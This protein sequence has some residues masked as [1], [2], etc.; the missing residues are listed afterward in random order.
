MATGALLLS[1]TGF[2]QGFAESVEGEA[3]SAF[4]GN[5]CILELESGDE[6]RGTFTS[7]TYVNN[8]FSKITVKLDN[9]EKQKFTPD[10]LVSMKIRSSDL[11]KMMMISESGSSL[12]E[13]G[14]TNFNDILNR[15]YIIFETA[16]TPKKT[17]TKR[18][19]QLLNAGFDNRIKVFAEPSAKTG[20]LNVGGIQVTGGEDAAYL[21]VKGGE[22]SIRV[23]KGSYDKDFGELYGDCPRMMEA[24]Q[25]GKIKWDDLAL[26]V[27]YYNQLC[28]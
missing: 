20:G 21:F 2:G 10:Q 14:N 25:N 17:D 5:E 3:M 18:L 22:K 15:E 28:E 23:K 6:I 9:G 26:H 7:A 4:Y 19:L 12:S 1:A 8:G 11:L 27:Y 16:L 13:L 24:F